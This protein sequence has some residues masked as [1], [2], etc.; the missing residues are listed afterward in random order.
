VTKEAELRSDSKTVEEKA[1]TEGSEKRRRFAPADRRLRERRA[2]DPADRGLQERG[3]STWGDRRMQ[4]RRSSSNNRQSAIGNL[5]A[6]HPSLLAFIENQI[7][8]GRS[9][10]DIAQ[11][12]GV[13]F[14]LKV[15]RAAL[16]AYRNNLAS[17]GTRAVEQAFEESREEIDR[18]ID[19]METHCTVTPRGFSMITGIWQAVRRW[20][21]GM[22]NREQGIGNRE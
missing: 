21:A 18:L 15:S 8:L 5:C 16:V 4:E 10:H 3:S 20:L 9:A 11:G 1:R 7:V 12:I 22:G 17:T 6:E 2:S 19:N 13:R 14:G